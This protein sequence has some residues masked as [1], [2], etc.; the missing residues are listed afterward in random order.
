MSERPALWPAI[1]R[2][3]TGRCPACG[4]GRLFRSYLK[5][6]EACS[7]CGE[8]FGHIRSDD[9]A[10]WLTILVV[11]HIFVPLLISVEQ[12]AEWPLWVSGIVWPAIAGLMCLAVLPFAKAVFVSAIWATGAPGSERDA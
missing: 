2:G 10:P 8:A 4:E 6:V 9:A 12:S 1:R 11:G 5:P 3:L 7:A